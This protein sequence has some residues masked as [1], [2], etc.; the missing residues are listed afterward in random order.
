MQIILA[1]ELESI[2]AINKIKT[3]VLLLAAFMF[4]GCGI[5]NIPTYDEGTKAAWSEVLNQYKRRA[6][7][8]PNLVNTVKG[9]AAHEEKV[10]LE[11]TEA[12]SKVGGITIDEN[13]LNNPQALQ[14]FEQAQDALSSALSRLMAVSERYPDLKANQNFLQLQAQLEGAENRISVARRDFIKSVQKY[15]T[16][17]RTFP[18][19][20]WHKI[21]Y[22][23]LKEKAQFD[24]PASENVQQTPEVQF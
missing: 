8:I 9:Y 1:F 21:L 22:S 13:I 18:G 16:E 15:N 19:L 2:M 14:R 11:V 5:N 6:D 7:L 12:R 10:F 20:I 4:T 17:L 24:V 23:S 3:F